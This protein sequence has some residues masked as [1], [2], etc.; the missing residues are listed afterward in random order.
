[1][2]ASTIV[3]FA[4][5]AAALGRWTHNKP[6]ASVALVVQAIFVVLI[7]S[8]MDQGKTE[9]VA[10]GLAWLVLAAVLLGKNTPITGLTAASFTGKA[11]TTTAA[12][13]VRS[14]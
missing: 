10:K 2:K 6:T 9:P 13:V 7:I 4:I 1:M 8:F 12:P 5:G 3:I 11:K 14:V